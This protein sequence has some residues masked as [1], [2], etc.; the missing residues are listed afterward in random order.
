MSLKICKKGE[1]MNN[2]LVTGGC[3]FI[4]SNFINYLLQKYDDINVI[5]VDALTYASD[6]SSLS[7]Y[8]N[9]SRYKFE[10]GNILNT[11]F[12]DQIFQKY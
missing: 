1:M 3:G 7:G 2:I 9:D 6:E 8:S 12:I 10:K 4:G 11:D 5:N